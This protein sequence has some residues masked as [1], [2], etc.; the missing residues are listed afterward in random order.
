VEE[1]LTHKRLCGGHA[2]AGVE[3]DSTR[4][5]QMGKW[6]A[7]ERS[8]GSPDHG[9]GMRMVMRRPEMDRSNFRKS[10]SNNSKKAVN[11][12]LLEPF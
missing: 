5:G 9:D 7:A 4:G 1:A 6:L 3:H 10:K 2:L 8:G 11:P 12:F